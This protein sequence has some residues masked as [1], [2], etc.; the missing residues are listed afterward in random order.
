MCRFRPA[1]EELEKHEGK[2]KN[3]S[4]GRMDLCN[5]Q[6]IELLQS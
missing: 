6:P 4:G 5:F 2:L 1:A 3:V